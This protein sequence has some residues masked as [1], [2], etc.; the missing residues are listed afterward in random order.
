MKLL[1]SL[2][3]SGLFE[4]FVFAA[5]RAAG[6]V[7]TAPNHGLTAAGSSFAP[8]F[9]ADGRSIVF[10]SHA[11]NLTTNI[12]ASPFLNL[13]SGDLVTRGVTLLSV[14]VHGQSTDSDSSFA[15]VSSN[16]Q[17]V[18]F[19]SAS[20]DLV[21]NDTNTAADIF[22]RDV[23]TGTTRLVT[24]TASSSASP[25]DP[26]SASSQPL[27]SNPEISQDGRWV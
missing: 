24:A 26:N 7:S 5:D 13:F 8:Q 20:G 15:S 10:A 14:S 6:I 21:A 9:A 11:K 17:F 25:P 27:S 1:L 4:N 2:L 19:A 22:V 3:L 18:A 16:G 12:I 23:V